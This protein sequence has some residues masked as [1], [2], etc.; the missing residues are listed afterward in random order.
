MTNKILASFA[1]FF[2]AAF[3]NPAAAPKPDFTGNWKLNIE[4][5][6]MGPMPPPTSMTQKIDH[7]DPVLKVTTSASGGPQGDMNYDVKYTTDGKPCTNTF[8]D[9]EATSTLTW[10]GEFLLIETKA[11]FGQGEVT[12]KG[13]WGLSPDGKTLKQTAHIETGGGAF[14]MTYTFDK[15]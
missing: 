5:S 14:D 10:E 11:D 13:K 2:M 8:F 6:E 3:A 15:Q 9:R 4:K 1:L 12:I 7:K